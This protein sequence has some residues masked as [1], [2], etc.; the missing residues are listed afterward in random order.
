MANNL[1]DEVVCIRPEDILP[2]INPM[3][4]SIS[5]TGALYQEFGWSEFSETTTKG[6]AFQKAY[7]FQE[8][9]ELQ[10]EIWKVLDSRLRQASD[11][12]VVWS[13]ETESTEASTNPLERRSED[14]PFG[15]EILSEICAEPIEDGYSH[16]A[17]KL[18]G[19]SFAQYPKKT[20]RCFVDSRFLVDVTIPYHSSSVLYH[21]FYGIVKPH[22]I[23][24]RTLLVVED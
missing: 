22:S 24:G 14:V 5:E 3:L 12:L 23:Q 19:E 10:K 15:T 4:A 21:V 11:L 2:K 16:P 9:A 20:F 7:C 13:R 18:L 6:S 17:E 1:S 8:S